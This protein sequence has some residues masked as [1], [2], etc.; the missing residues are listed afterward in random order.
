M[1]NPRLDLFCL[2]SPLLLPKEDTGFESKTSHSVLQFPVEHNKVKL[3]S[4]VMLPFWIF[5]VLLSLLFLSTRY[6]FTIS[7]PPPQ[8]LPLSSPLCLSP[9]FFS[10]YGKRNLGLPLSLEASH[11]KVKQSRPEGSL[12][13]LLV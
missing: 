9:P 8:F 11:L 1:G 7:L 2:S 4:L 12:G 6:Y 10:L 5:L 13:L 3:F